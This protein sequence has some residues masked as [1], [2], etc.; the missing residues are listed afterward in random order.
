[1][2]ETQTLSETE[3]ITKLRAAQIELLLLEKEEVSASDLRS[4]IEQIEVAIL[5]LQL[6]R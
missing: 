4:V 5:T 3:I 1:M 6:Q 2:P